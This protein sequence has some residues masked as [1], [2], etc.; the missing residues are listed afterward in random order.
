M[1]TDFDPRGFAMA[2]MNETTVL[3]TGPTAGAPGARYI[4]LLLSAWLFA[5]AWVWVHSLA[6]ETNTWACGIA[7]AVFALIA[8]SVPA[9]R[10]LNTLLSIWLFIS[11]FVLPTSNSTTVWNNALVAVAMFV[12]SLIGFASDLPVRRRPV[13][14]A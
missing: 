13:R 3:R 1:E 12:V 5:S 2:N 14:P 10:Y 8:L 4:N 7:G 6:Q 9:V 11:A